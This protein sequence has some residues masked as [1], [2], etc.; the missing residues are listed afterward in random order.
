MADFFKMAAKNKKIAFK[1]KI[2]RLSIIPGRLRSENF[3]E[4]HLR[5]IQRILFWIKY[6]KVKKVANFQDGRQNNRNKSCHSS[7]KCPLG[8]P[9]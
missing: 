2:N 8:E 6:G 5:I 7:D 1:Y 4:N 3:I 9:L